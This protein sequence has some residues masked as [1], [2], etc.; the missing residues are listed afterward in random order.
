MM[1]LDSGIRPYG[2]VRD[3]IVQDFDPRVMMGKIFI[4]LGGDGFHLYQKVKAI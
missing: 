1:A 4:V 3:E 2:R